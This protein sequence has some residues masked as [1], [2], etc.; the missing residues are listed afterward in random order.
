MADTLC[1][2]PADPVRVGVLGSCRNTCHGNLHTRGWRI[3]Y[4]GNLA[5]HRH[6]L[7][8]VVTEDQL[9]ALPFG[10]RLRFTI[11]GA[12]LEKTLGDLWKVAGVPGVFGSDDICRNRTPMEILD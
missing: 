3:A 9:D 12:K 7:I 8:T 4:G 5:S 6:T 1:S 11:S 10:T 2:Y